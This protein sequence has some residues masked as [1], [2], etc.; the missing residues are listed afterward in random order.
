[1]S[2]NLRTWMGNFTSGEVQLGI[3]DCLSKSS[4]IQVKS[5]LKPDILIA[6]F[7][8]NII[9]APVQIIFKPSLIRQILVVF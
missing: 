3:N 5:G 4:S 9:E 2:I 7:S 8:W 1:M 6:V